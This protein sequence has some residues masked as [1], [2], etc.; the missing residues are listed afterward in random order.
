MYM[1]Y[2]CSSNLLRWSRILSILK[3]ENNKKGKFQF[4][5]EINIIMIEPLSMLLI[6][7]RRSLLFCRPPSHLITRN[8]LSSFNFWLVSK[9]FGKNSKTRTRIQ[10]S[11]YKSFVRNN[12]NKQEWLSWKFVRNCYISWTGGM[13]KGTFFYHRCKI[14]I[15]WKIFKY[16]VHDS[17]SFPLMQNFQKP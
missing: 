10:L 1:Q 4:P 12:W 6:L 7:L 8:P 11:S 2:V 17:I 16:K 13:L 14:R 9:L 15:K 5:P 3:V